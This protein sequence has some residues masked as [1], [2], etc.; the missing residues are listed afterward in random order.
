MR[1]YRPEEFE[2]YAAHRCGAPVPKEL[3]RQ[4]IAKPA[5]RKA[6]VPDLPPF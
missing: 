6:N 4:E 2:V 1:K 5:K 3:A